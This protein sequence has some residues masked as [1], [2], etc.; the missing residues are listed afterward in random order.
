MSYDRH[1][2]IQ[3]LGLI[4]RQAGAEPEVAELV[5][6]YGRLMVDSGRLLS[7]EAFPSGSVEHQ[8]FNRLY[9]DNRD[10]DPNFLRFLAA[11]HGEMARRNLPP[12]YTRANLAYRLGILPA[13]LRAVIEQRSRHYRVK[14]QPKRRGGFRVI[15]VPQAPLR[16]IQKWIFRSILA[17][18]KHQTPAHGFVRGR[19]IVTNAALHQNKRVVMCVDIED[20]FPSIKFR[21]VRK[22][23][24]RLGYPYS[25]A[26][27]LANLC[28][29][30][31]AL[32]QGTS[33][34]P[35]LV[36][37]ACTNLDKRLT[38]LARSLGHTYSRYVDDLVFSSDDDRLASILPF[39][40]QI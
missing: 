28:T 36:N 11:W 31:G 26:V 1:D 35:A 34:S 9:R 13:I 40:R 10:A 24:Q 27:D 25:V 19:S 6:A 30:Q 37:L 38:G 5:V 7:F 16:R 39:L 29:L 23:F 3:D 33:T 21:T 8:V 12:I 14:R 2:T 32:P 20:F 17:E 4:Q 15:H 22:A 18:F